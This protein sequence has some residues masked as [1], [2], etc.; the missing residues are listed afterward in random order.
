LETDEEEFESS[1]LQVPT[2]DVAAFLSQLHFEKRHLLDKLPIN[3][4]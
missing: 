4:S 1:L 2:T 3:V